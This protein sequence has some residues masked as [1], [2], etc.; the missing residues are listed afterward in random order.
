MMRFLWS[1]LVLCALFGVS[2]VSAQ[3]LLSEEI[4]EDSVTGQDVVEKAKEFIGVPYR[5][6]QMNPK[7]G[8]DCSGFTT[9]VFKSLNI[10]LTRSSRSQFREGVKIDDRRDLQQG[11][12]VFFTGTRSKKTIGHV[13]IVTDVDEETGEFEFIHAGRKGICINSSSD[14]YYDRRYVGARR[15]LG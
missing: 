9:Y 10:C 5:Y 6:G 15:V 8:C 2:P 13:G 12:L 3:T 14:G 7:R 4:R 1:L 11:D